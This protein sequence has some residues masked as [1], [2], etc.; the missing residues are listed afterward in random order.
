[1]YNLALQARASGFEVCVFTLSDVTRPNNLGITFHK[2]KAREVRCPIEQFYMRIKKII[3]GE[4]GN[5][6]YGLLEISENASE[7]ISHM[8]ET[9]DIVMV[10]SVPSLEVLKVG[11]IIKKKLGGSCRWVVDFRD[12]PLINVMGEFSG[13]SKVKKLIAEA[14]CVSV[15][16]K[17]LGRLL[18]LKEFTVVPNGAE[19][20]RYGTPV[21]IGAG[22]ENKI[23]LV[24]SGTLDNP[25][26]KSRFLTLAE[27]ISRINSSDLKIKVSLDC[28]SSTVLKNIPHCYDVNFFGYLPYSELREKLITY[29]IG[30]SLTR[31]VDQYAIPMKIYEYLSLEL[32]VLSFGPQD[33]EVSDMAEGLDFI[34]H[35][36]TISKVKFDLLFRLKNARIPSNF[37]E[38]VSFDGGD[39][40]EC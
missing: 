14:D 36:T 4:R 31:A 32:P 12:P 29:D 8:G 38:K 5:K 39:I 33:S 7:I 22:K 26:R 6:L 15:T 40:L 19:I 30:V 28:Y 25:E 9:Q 27:Q 34:S 20:K 17:R 24:Y 18:G 16:T 21:K 3:F 10:T 2:L 37:Y 1:M 11:R 13:F 35:C 23:K